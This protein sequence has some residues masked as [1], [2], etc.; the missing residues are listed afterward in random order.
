MTFTCVASL[1][2]S[3]GAPCALGTWEGGEAD[4]ADKAA[5]VTGRACG[6]ITGIG[7]TATVGDACGAGC[8]TAGRRD[9][10]GCASSAGDGI[11][12]ATRS[13]TC[14]GGPPTS[15]NARYNTLADCPAKRPVI[16][17]KLA[18]PQRCGL[19]ACA[20][21]FVMQAAHPLEP[22]TKH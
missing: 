7:A 8:G 15:R 10:T 18:A 5:A 9:V 20:P 1:P 11:H 14:A 2:A 16:V 4:G 19:M 6:A 3:S 17:W 22:S 13:N 12:L 21:D